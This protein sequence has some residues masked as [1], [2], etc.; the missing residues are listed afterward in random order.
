MRDVDYYNTHF[1]PGEAIPVETDFT[2]D[3]DELRMSP[4]YTAEP[5]DEEGDDDQLD[6]ES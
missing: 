6:D 1:N 5:P 2:K 3:I 4:D